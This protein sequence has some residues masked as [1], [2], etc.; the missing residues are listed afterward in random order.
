MLNRPTFGGHIKWVIL[1]SFHTNATQNHWYNWRTSAHIQRAYSSW[2]PSF[3][4]P[5]GVKIQHQNRNHRHI[6]WKQRMWRWLF[7][8]YYYNSANYL[9]MQH[10]EKIL[11][12]KSRINYNINIQWFITFVWHTFR[13]FWHACAKS[14]AVFCH[15]LYR[16]TFVYSHNFTP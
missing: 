14:C 16:W 11:I 15:S 7:I 6:R 8:L 3:Q 12:L 13:D 1:A 9:P 4:D 2:N 5:K 10:Y